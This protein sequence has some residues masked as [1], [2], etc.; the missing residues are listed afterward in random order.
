MRVLE[1]TMMCR[2]RWRSTSTAREV[3]C[4]ADS[5]VQRFGLSSSHP[6]SSAPTSEASGAEKR[7]PSMSR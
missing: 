5:T 2:A 4:H 1:V 3:A 6:T 7:T